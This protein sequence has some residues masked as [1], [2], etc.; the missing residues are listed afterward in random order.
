MLIL[1]N[2]HERI[3]PKRARKKGCSMQYDHA[4]V[5]VNEEYKTWLDDSSDL[6]RKRK[7]LKIY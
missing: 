7:Y 4:L 1:D 6:V 3:A 5:I 2:Q